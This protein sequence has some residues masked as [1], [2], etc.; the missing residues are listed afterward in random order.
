MLLTSSDP[1]IS[2]IR[3]MPKKKRCEIDEV[4]KSLILNESND[5]SNTESDDDSDDNTSPDTSSTD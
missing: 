4:M 3:L 1:Y 2:S 5:S